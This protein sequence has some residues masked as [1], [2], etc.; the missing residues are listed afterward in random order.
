MDL[1]DTLRFA[2]KKIE[3][4]ARRV[5]FLINNIDPRHLNK[6]RDPDSYDDDKDDYR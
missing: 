4:D 2:S 6:S 3:E 5:E 1:N